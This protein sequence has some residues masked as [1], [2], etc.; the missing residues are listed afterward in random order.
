MNGK[1]VLI[2]GATGFI[3]FHLARRLARSGCTVHLLIR[4][5]GES[6]LAE[7]NQPY[8][9]HY[10]DGTTDSVIKAV[11][12]AAPEVV[13]HLASLFL[14]RHEP[15]DI[16]PLI[17]SNLLFGTQL[18]EAMSLTGKTLLVNAGTGW[19]HYENAAYSPV[20]LYA[21]TKQA[22][23]AIIR[24]YVEARGFHVT[25]LKLF[26]TYG[27]EDPR[28]KL[29][30]LLAQ[31]AFE[32][33]KLTMSPG[34]QLIDLVNIDDVLDAFEIAGER[35]LAGKGEPEETFAVSSGSPV[36][37]KK[38]IELFQSVTGN[39]IEVEF[40]ALPYRPREVMVPWTKGSRLPGWRPKVSLEEGLRKMDWSLS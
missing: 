7:L 23:E 6:R 32:K 20:A 11:D 28:P 35:L 12:S 27:P 21:A 30:S 33:K 10:Y 29:L 9:P 31:A 4:K 24:Y 13:F 36:S 39:Q 37:L 15:R 14:A 8:V 40:G 17:N 19:Q 25:T 1:N 38:L 16:E 22:F 3:G 34:E 18:L 26:D 2:T 5:G